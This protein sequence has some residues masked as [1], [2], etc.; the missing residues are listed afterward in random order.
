MLAHHRHIAPRAKEGISVYHKVLAAITSFILL[1]IIFTST[2][3]AIM[4]SP[5]GSTNPAIPIEIIISDVTNIED[6]SSSSPSLS[7]AVTL[8]NTN[9]DEPVSFLRWSSPFDTAAAAMGVYIFISESTGQPAHCQNLKFKRKV[10][11]SGVYNPEDTIRI[12]AGETLTREVTIKTPGV[13]LKRG[14]KYSI[15][16]SGFWMYVLVGDHSELRTGQEGVL[17]GDFESKAVKFKV[18]AQ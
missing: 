10:P 6:K 13:T 11:D 7:L 2:Q 5:E 12:E 16:A 4:P 17:R 15:T 8:R 18:P 3:D 14:E 1:Y 9:P